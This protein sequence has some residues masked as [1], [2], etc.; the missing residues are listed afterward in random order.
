MQPVGYSEF[1]DQVTNKLLKR[2][3]GSFIFAAVLIEPG[4]MVVEA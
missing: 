2:V 4:F 3:S 1:V